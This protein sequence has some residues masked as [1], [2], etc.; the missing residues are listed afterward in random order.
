MPRPKNRKLLAQSEIFQ[1]QVL[2]AKCSAGE[3]SEE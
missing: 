2:T 1:K 3:Q